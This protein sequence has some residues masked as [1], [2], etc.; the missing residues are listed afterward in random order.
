[1]VTHSQPLAASSRT[2]I[3]VTAKSAFAAAPYWLLLVGIYVAFGFLWYFASKEKLID[4]NGQMPAGLA[5][6]YEGS[7]LASFPGVDTAWLLL[8]LAEAAGCVLF[9][10]SLV[11]GEFLPRRAKPI[12]RTAVAW[13]VATFGVMAFAQNTIGDND[14]V[15]S[16][17]T[18]MAGSIVVLAAVV[19]LTPKRVQSWISTTDEAKA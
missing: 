14:S 8:G 18:Y 1:M 15:A 16:L 6:G 4:Q 11:T 19:A 17:F 10:A 9:V 7:F 3:R 2:S 12:L 5:K 13:S